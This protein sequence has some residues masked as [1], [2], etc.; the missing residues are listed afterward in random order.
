MSQQGHESFGEVYVPT[1]YETVRQQLA[2]A[3]IEANLIVLD[4]SEPS[5]LD[6]IDQLAQRARE[7]A[8]GA[9]EVIIQ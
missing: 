1:E 7:L 2:D 8:Q 9:N 4:G 3:R 6:H 5:N